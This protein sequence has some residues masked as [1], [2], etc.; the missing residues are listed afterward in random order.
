MQWY[1]EIGESDGLVSFATG[2]VLGRTN[3]HGMMPF[4]DDRL[5][6][7]GVLIARGA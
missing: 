1:Q 4:R 5:S 3:E 6:G 7:S 2:V